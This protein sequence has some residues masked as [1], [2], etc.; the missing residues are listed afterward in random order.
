[1]DRYTRRPLL[2]GNTSVPTLTIPVLRG[3]TR[4]DNATLAFTG[5]VLPAALALEINGNT[6]T[7][8]LT[9]TDI[10]TVLS[11]INTAI[12]VDGHSAIDQAGVL[13]IIAA[14][15]GEGTYVRCLPYTGAGSDASFSLG[16]PR[17]PDPL[18]TMYGGETSWSP[19]GLTEENPLGTIFASDGEDVTASVLNRATAKLADNVDQLHLALQREIA[20]PMI[21]KINSGDPRAIPNGSGDIEQVNLSSLST[22]DPSF[23]DRVYLGKNL[24]NVS[25]LRD[26]AQY[27][28]VTDLNQVEIIVGGRPVRVA[29]VTRGPRSTGLPGYPDDVSAPT[30]PV[31]NVGT[32]VPADGR[33]LLGV[34]FVKASGG[35]SEVLY[36]SAVRSVGAAFLTAG[37]VNR[38]KAVISGATQNDPFNHNGTY[39]VDEAIDEEHLMLR[40]VTYGDRGELNP[41]GVTGSVTIS[42]GGEFAEDVY[43]TFEP[44]IP[45]GRDFM[46]VVG[47]GYKM[48]DLPA[49]HLLRLAISTSEEVDDLVQK[50]IRE[51]K[52]PLV[53]STD[54]FT[55]YPFAHEIIGG[56]SYAGEA[57]VSQEL[58]W[59]RL[60]LQGAY[61][62]Q[63]RGAGGGYFVFVDS[64]PPEFN[65]L[66][67]KVPSRGTLE[68]SGSS[69]TILSG[70][71][72]NIVGNNFTLDD[73]GKHIMVT[74]G[75]GPLISANAR[76]AQFMIVDYIDSENVVLEPGESNPTIP[77]GGS[78][79]WQMWAGAFS[80]V[81][82]AFTSHVLMGN[83]WGRLG[84]VHEEDRDPASQFGQDFMGIREVTDGPGSYELQTVKGLT[85]TAGSSWVTL[86]FDPTEKSTIRT[87]ADHH[88][89]LA[90]SIVKLTHTNN[91]D[92][93]YLVVEID[94]ATNR[95]RLMNFDGTFPAF[96]PG[97]PGE[98]VWA[99]FYLPTMGVM[100]VRFDSATSFRT[101]R[102]FFED[103]LEW[104]AAQ[105]SL[106][107][108]SSDR[109]HLGVIG[110]DWRGPVYG[111][112]IGLLNS[113]TW[114]AYRNG[115][116]S[117]GAGIY[118]DA[119]MP[120]LGILSSLVAAE[121][122][123]NLAPPGDPAV[124]AT[125]LERGGWAGFFTS[126]TH[127][128]DMN[129][130]DAALKGASL[131]AVALGDDPAFVVE[132]WEAA[133]GD[134]TSPHPQ[135]DDFT[136]HLT[137]ASSYV[138]RRDGFSMLQSGAQEYLG[139]V[140]QVDPR[141]YYSIN[142]WDEE[143]WAGMYSEL[144]G[145]FRFS[146]APMSVDSERYYDT[147]DPS[148]PRYQYLARLGQPGQIWPY[149]HADSART[150]YELR[151]PNPSA[152]RSVRSS[153]FVILGNSVLE[154]IEDPSIYIGQQ[155]FLDTGDSGDPEYG[156]YT[157][158]NVHLN[159]P[160]GVTP[161]IIHI[162][163]VYRDGTTLP[164]D[165]SPSEMKAVVRGNR[166]H[167]ANI[168]VESWMLFGTYRVADTSR[169]RDD[170]FLSLGGIGSA[171]TQ[172]QNLGE[173]FPS[174]GHPGMLGDPAFGLNDYANGMSVDPTMSGIRDA[175]RQASRQPIAN[176]AWSPYA[177]WSES[178]TVMDFNSSD[179]GNLTF[180]SSEWV[181]RE[182]GVSSALRVS[183][184]PGKE[185]GNDLTNS[186][187]PANAIR[188]YWSGGALETDPLMVRALTRVS[189]SIRRNH[190]RVRVRATMRW[191][192]AGSIPA[193]TKDVTF[194]LVEDD[195]TTVI[196]TVS[197]ETLTNGVTRDIEVLL[198]PEATYRDLRDAPVDT[199]AD[200]TQAILQLG[201][202]IT[203]MDGEADERI[204]IY[205][206]STELEAID[207]HHGA[208]IN[209]GP[210]ISSGYHL[211][212]TAM[213]YKSYGPADAGPYGDS[214]FGAEIPW[215]FQGKY[216]AETGTDSGKIDPPSMSVLTGR[217]L[218]ESSADGRWDT[219]ETFL[220]ITPPSFFWRRGAN[221]ACMHFVGN[222]F[223]AGARS[224]AAEADFDDAFSDMVGHIVRLDPPHGSIMSTLQVATSV[225]SAVANGL[226][227]YRT[228]SCSGNEIAGSDPGFVIELLRHSIMPIDTL[229]ERKTLPGV[230]SMQAVDGWAFGF[231]EV[232]ARFDVDAD[233]NLYTLYPNQND[234]TENNCPDAV[235][236]TQEGFSAGLTETFQ[237]TSVDLLGDD[238]GTAIVSDHKM[239]HVD[240]R[241]YAYSLVIRAWGQGGDK[242]MNIFGI[243]SSAAG[244]V[245]GIC[246]GVEGTPVDGGAPTDLT[247]DISKLKFRGAVLGCSYTR[248]NP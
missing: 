38:D 128:M 10:N 85:L 203:R 66:T 101:G 110:I 219:S 92:G 239:L 81:P 63:G 207:V 104:K 6:Y 153:G 95:I 183:Y 56:A 3:Q 174:T 103:A 33:N 17:H 237:L 236:Y 7:V 188:L 163:E 72:L 201:L 129:A 34:D 5:L 205:A 67:P 232:I 141:N 94:G 135:V 35:I 114:T 222:R 59:R 159:Q 27:F 166:W 4:R 194:S 185:S 243:S 228:A 186:G 46:V 233:A 45:A 88:A 202:G 13:H 124:D 52:G 176:A 37:V 189:A 109:T 16:F 164:N 192:A 139:A 241:Q 136:F 100:D 106:F 244:A 178:N 99:H 79:L 87:L 173:Y 226:G 62:G 214:G 238:G 224:I 111:G 148:I 198:N 138:G 190:F 102:V 115:D 120:A 11:D 23:S 147:N 25:P 96:Q 42:S 170:E 157:I 165:P 149:Y 217:K 9:G 64:Q 145:A 15:G 246:F 116:A 126:I 41:D 215:W 146:L 208:L 117:S 158:I 184:D 122:G 20:L 151:A 83:N 98:P 18:A 172:M 247:T 84:F 248:I 242:D 197:T 187:E 160:G 119:A 127:S 26:I 150:V 108:V 152:S 75:T 57:D 49:D 14:S 229:P 211:S 105:D 74:G 132:G 112:I 181:F 29:A 77:V 30:S 24:T 19:F 36:R 69:A 137:K 179:F 212:G 40:G 140:Y 71:V 54:D 182:S 168:D 234:T 32:W 175:N 210:I 131:V 193:A 142:D 2:L 171:D 78:Y 90:Q 221:D 89:T 51:M 169:T 80:G 53:D 60:T 134:H 22:L 143:Q 125:V 200:A 216:T 70:N 231:S 240:R 123:T 225:F 50:V 86:P 1:M 167:W 235:T 196:S 199:F 91:S 218:I 28:A 133:P 107:G 245:D 93:W 155:L 130:G 223:A 162:L 55:A 180:R 206:C 68:A 177:T 220:D 65:N 73:V 156:L 44:A 76:L 39:T 113:D 118:L 204:Y 61:D 8:L 48:K 43:L 191:V 154:R 230:G 213:D 121:Q 227:V 12:N 21:V 97:A 161:K 31:G 209:E 82:A 195:E 144:A 47:G 58:L